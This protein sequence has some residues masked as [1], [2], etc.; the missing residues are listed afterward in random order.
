MFQGG[1]NQSYDQYLILRGY[2]PSSS[3]L[4]ILKRALI[5]SW[6]EPG[7]HEFWRVWNSGIGYLLFRLYLA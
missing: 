7:L 5:D 6:A 2:D 1:F 4:I 3:K